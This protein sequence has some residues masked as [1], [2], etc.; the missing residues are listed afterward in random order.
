[1][2]AKKHEN[3]SPSTLNQWKQTWPNLPLFNEVVTTSRD[4]SA[5]V[6]RLW[7]IIKTEA[8]NIMEKFTKQIPK[9]YLAILEK[10]QQISHISSQMFIQTQE[11]IQF[12]S[13]TPTIQLMP[14]L[15]YLHSVG[16]IV[17][18]NERL[19]CANP[20]NISKV[21]AKFIAPEQVQLALPHI[22]DGKA[23]ILTTEHAGR[24]LEMT[25]DDPN[26]LVELEAMSHFGICYKLPTT[27]EQFGPSFLFPSL[28]KESHGNTLP[29]YQILM[30]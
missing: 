22:K 23:V 11:L 14:A 4:D 27:P 8:T 6:D 24:V 12:Y 17:L 30:F 25:A 7:K 9:Q 10:I 29:L 2:S 20:M 21:M 1:M 3:F 28:A 15:R 16:D 26:L 13:E 18:L 5:S 19:I